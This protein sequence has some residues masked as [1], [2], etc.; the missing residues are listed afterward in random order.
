MNNQFGDMRGKLVCITGGS[1]GIG[2]AIALELAQAGA[3]LVLSY[4][5]NEQEAA[6]V[7]EQGR[8]LG[9]QVHLV[10]GNVGQAEGISRIAEAARV[11]G[12]LDGLVNNA[13]IYEGL[14]LEKTEADDWDRMIDTNLRSVFLLIKEL[15]PSLREGT[16]G[17][18]VNIS[19]ILGLK[20]AG[21]A[22]AYQISKAGVAHL[23]KS[24]SLELAPHIRVNCVA[25]G[26]IQTDINRGGWENAEFR[27]RVENDTPLKRWGMPEDIAQTV[28]FLLSDSAKFVT[29]Q[30]ISVD[31]GKGLA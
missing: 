9:V 31:G 28:R 11:Y 14:S 27:E 25:P 16:G 22:H 7:A 19:S 23:S 4:Q 17:A 13:G 18:V 21:G 2:R 10:Q 8:S 29:G 15:A 24:L 26:F 1:R 5:S 20:P 3:N 12:K 30:V 6:A